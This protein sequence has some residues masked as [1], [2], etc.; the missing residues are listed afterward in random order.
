MKSITV[1]IAAGGTGGH[2]YP[3]LAVAV[4]LMQAGQHVSWL[5][6]AHGIESHLVPEHGIK[7]HA[8]PFRGWRGKGLMS[9]FKLPWKLVQALFKTWLIMR[10]VKPQVV[11]A[12]GGYGSVAGGLAARLLR[13]PLLIHEQNAMPGLANR[14]LSLLAC[15][16]LVGFAGVLG[17]RAQHVGNPVR[18]QF[19]W[20][21]EPTL[22]LSQHNPE[23]LR[24]LVVGGS[25]GSA[26]LNEMVPQAVLQLKS[27][28]RVVVFHQ[29]GQAAL[30][31]TRS[32]YRQYGDVKVSP[33]IDD[34]ATAYAW[35]DV[36][37]CRSGAMTLAEIC[38]AGVAAIVV[39]LPH[40]VDDHQTHNAMYLSERN[41]A[42]VLPQQ[43]LNVTSLA[44]LLYELAADRR[45]L[46]QLASAAR[47][48]AHLD[49][50][51]QIMRRCLSIG[52]L[53]A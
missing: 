15:Q 21:A 11:L 14:V 18:A 23:E 25:Q 4:E 51:S 8:V 43:R 41:A 19:P 35:S 20:I 37:V 13:V 42:I 12:M 31:A 3:G 48:L 36:V 32:R 5:G 6:T 9:W 24:I 17:A 29:T 22:R 44:K 49:A 40:A 50:A 26:A 38:A 52:G 10:Q 1:L 16:V 27:K 30:E 33:F 53:N 2:V 46:L 7:L 45:Q 28:L 47:Q 39:P 34:I